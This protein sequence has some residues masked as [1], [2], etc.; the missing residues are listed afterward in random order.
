MLVRALSAGLEALLAIG[1]EPPGKR[2]ASGLEAFVQGVGGVAREVS[3]TLDEAVSRLRR[4]VTLP[5]GV[6]G[7]LL[8]AVVPLGVGRGLRRLAVVVALCSL[9]TLRSGAGTLRSLL[10]RGWRTSTLPPGR[11]RP[12]RQLLPMQLVPPYYSTNAPAF[13]RGRQMVRSWSGGEDVIV[14]CVDLTHP[15]SCLLVV[16]RAG[17]LLFSNGKLEPR[18]VALTDILLLQQQANWLRVLYLLPTEQTSAHNRHVEAHEIELPTLS[19]AED[20]N[21]TLRMLCLN[22]RGVAMNSTPPSPLLRTVLLAPPS[23]TPS[24]EQL[25]THDS[26]RHHTRG[27]PSSNVILPHERL[28]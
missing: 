16:T 8:S 24:P 9:R 13:L 17:L 28:P 11:S 21:E 5:T 20:L 10:Q 2:Q 14:C 6:E 22:A 12:P 23:A 3:Q 15:P 19:A 27:I 25:H 7:L 18:E 1:V 4:V 26:P